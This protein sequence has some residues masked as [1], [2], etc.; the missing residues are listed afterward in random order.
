MMTAMAGV[1][2]DYS[3]RQALA[4]MPVEKIGM[5]DRTERLDMIDFYEANLLDRTVNNRRGG[6]ARLTHL[7][8]STFTIVNGEVETISGYLL[9]GKSDTLVAIIRT[10]ATPALDSKLTVYDRQ[11]QPRTKSWTEPAMKQWGKSSAK[12]L[13]TEYQLRGD[14]L[15][16]RDQTSEWNPEWAPKVKELKYLWNR[17]SEKFVPLK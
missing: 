2:A 6:K 13:L 14:T 1:R 5:I 3:A 9:A 17:K 7:T 4:D 11:W 12:F 15:T 8:D 10:L 16:L